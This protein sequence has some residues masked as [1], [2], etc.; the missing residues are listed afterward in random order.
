MQIVTPWTMGGNAVCTVPAEF[1]ASGLPI[2]L[3]ICAAPHKERKLLQLAQAYE[4]VT[5]FV[6]KFP[7]KY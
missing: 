3:Q 6:A 7:P 4:R 5:D 2:G 1:G